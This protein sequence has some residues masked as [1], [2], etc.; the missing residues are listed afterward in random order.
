MAR[1]NSAT[2]V[3]DKQIL[4]ML[5]KEAKRRGFADKLKDTVSG[6]QGMSASTGALP[7]KRWNW[8]EELENDRKREE[9]RRLAAEQRRL[10]ASGEFSSGYG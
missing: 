3:S 1:S 5:R 6:A 9:R 8:R 7:A 2:D 4:R 10:K